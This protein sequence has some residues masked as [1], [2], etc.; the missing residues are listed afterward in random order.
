MASL[1]LSPA[2]RP[3]AISRTAPLITKRSFNDITVATPPNPSSTPRPIIRQGPA[4]GGRS[5]DSGHTVTVFGATGFLARYLI[6]K[7]A[8]QGTQVVVPYRDEDEKRRLR[9]AG[10]L[11]QIV[12]LEWDARIPEQTA[13]AIRHSDVV[14]NL[15]GRDYETRNY[16]YGDVHVDV[17]QSI[18]QIAADMN[19]PRLVHVSHLNASPDSTS[20]FY[21]TKYAG[22]RA[23]RDAFPE[24]TIVRP[25][26]MFGYEDRFLN[27]L[28][29][30]PFLFKLNEGLTK[31]M[32]VHVIDVAQAL[33]LMLNAPV[34]STSST[35]ALPGPDIYTHN[36]LI[37]LLSTFTLR[38]KTSAPTLPKPVALFLANCL[39]RGLW[40][41]TISPDEIERKYIDDA[42]A[43][44]FEIAAAGEG[45]GPS[46]WNVGKAVQMTGVDGEPVK[47]WADLDMEPDT[48]EEHAIKVLRR[49][50]PA[51]GYDLPVEAHVQKSPKRYH[52][53][54]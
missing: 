2:L 4:T 19:V 36:E 51:I 21:R 23:V 53:L 16:K 42:G 20:E 32:P 40:W 35:F 14:Y 39:N 18:A 1:R 6:Q 54:P 12:P 11:G 31:T 7:L 15:V 3:K 47:S 25:S 38:P 24:A 9:P 10:D 28:A 34:T 29:S 45:E 27:L 8:R 30:W 43:D 41:P 48:L 5:S 37:Q 33:N 26:T 17:A 49:Y 44:A 22:E 13:E 50:R 52:V 46:G